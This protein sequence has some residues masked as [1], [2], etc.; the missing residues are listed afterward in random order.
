MTKDKIQDFTFRVTT[1]NKTEMIVILYDIGITYIDDAVSK[2]DCADFKGFRNEIGRIRNTLRELMNSVDTS[3]EIGANILKLYIFCSR[4]LTS[5]FLNFDKNSL[6][7]VAN[8]FKNLKEAYEEVSKNDTSG[9]VMEHAETVFNGLTYNRD[10]RSE[11]VSNG[12]TNR[13]FLA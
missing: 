11:S 8:I 10:L 3:N 1:A 2:L 4:E 13:G 6:Y 7:H 9:P 12:S 5:A